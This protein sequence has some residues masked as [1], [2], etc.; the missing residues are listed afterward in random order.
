MTPTATHLPVLEKLFD[1]YDIEIVLEFGMGEHST[2]FFVN[3]GVQLCSV[4][5]DS[6]AWF[7]KICTQHQ[8]A[9]NFCGMNLAGKK[10]ESAVAVLNLTD[11]KFD[12][13][14]VDGRADT[15][16]DIVNA[17]FQKTDL[18]V[19][20]DTEAHSYGWESIQVPHFWREKVYTEVKPWTTVW[21]K[22]G[23]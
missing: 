1:Q 20:H 8:S 22:E 14:F 10:K 16:V 23:E 18:I 9:K 19:A 15:R 6:D 7:E 3:R 5:E 12:L 11:V 4:E 2:A 21:R 17:A 13:I